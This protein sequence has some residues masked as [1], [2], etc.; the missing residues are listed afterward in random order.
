[1]LLA[2]QVDIEA[3]IELMELTLMSVMTLTPQ[4][5]FD[6]EMP[7]ILPPSNH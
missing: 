1:M 6:G 4:K 2:N 5:K 7:L 3:Y